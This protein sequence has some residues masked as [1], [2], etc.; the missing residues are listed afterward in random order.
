MGGL[1]LRSTEHH[2]PAAFLSSQVACQEL[3]V[4]LDSLY[5]WDPN[6]ETSNSFVALRDVNTRVSHNNQLQLVEGSSPRQQTLSH[7]MDSHTLQSIRSN[8]HNNVYFQAHL[9]HTGA[10]GAGTWLHTV[11][12]KALGTHVDSQLYRTMVQRWLRVPIHMSEY[13]CPYCDELVDKYGDHCLTCSCG[14]DRTKRHNLLRNQVFHL[15]NS[16][17]L[18]PELERPGLLQLRPL[19]GSSHESGAARDPNINRRPADVYLPKWRRGAPAALDFAVTSGLRNDMVNK[20]AEDG[21]SAARAYEELKRSHMDTEAICQEE[22]ITFIPM[23]CEADGGSWGPAAHQVWSELAK[24]KSVL[25]GEHSSIIATRILQS[26]GLILHREN[27]R[28]ILRRPPRSATCYSDEL[29]A[30]SAACSSF[31]DS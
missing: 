29:L 1:G 26:L 24:Y 23:V 19:I 17:G 5:N 21:S 15:C 12:S 10:S 13:H 20:S 27:A 6:N 16:S 14:G 18:S 8:A 28:S 4:K 30:A 9:N 31:Q 11:P 22:G 3:C 25:T 7:N 2:S